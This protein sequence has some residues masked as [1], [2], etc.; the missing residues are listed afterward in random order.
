MGINPNHRC[1]AFAA[2][3]CEYGSFTN[4]PE[5]G[6][7][8]C[9]E[10]SLPVPE[11]HGIDELVCE[12]RD[13]HQNRFDF[14]FVQTLRSRRLV[15]EIRVSFQHGAADA[16]LWIPGQILGAIGEARYAGRMDFVELLG[17]VEIHE[18]LI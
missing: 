5:R 13:A 17:S 14:K 15:H 3:R 18:V 12:S 2:Y 9:F 1:F 10:V 11:S 16:R 7:G 8:E 4:D 6:R